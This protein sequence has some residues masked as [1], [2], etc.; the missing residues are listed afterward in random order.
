[1]KKNA[2]KQHSFSV[3][4]S[5][6]QEK[7]IKFQKSYK[8]PEKNIAPGRR[9]VIK[10]ANV[11]MG[12]CQKAGKGEMQEVR[13]SIESKQAVG[14]ERDHTE[15]KMQGTL[16]KQGEAR[17]IEYTDMETGDA[18]IITMQKGMVSMQKRGT[19]ETDF[20]FEQGKTCSTLYKTP[21]GSLN[22]TI[23]PTHVQVKLEERSGKID[24]EYVMNIAGAQ[25]V[26]QLKLCYEE[27]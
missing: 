20:I 3:V 4:Q 13:I 7:N 14:S 15:M 24:L 19:I 10:L 5:K 2:E 22:A 16:Q 17:V 9:C 8:I 6:M 25:V 11:Q 18:T 1:M 23:L 12:F 21:F 27:C 26:T